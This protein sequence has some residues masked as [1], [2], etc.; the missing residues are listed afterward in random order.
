M[1]FIS[2]MA[3]FSNCRMF[4]IITDKNLAEF[5]K[6]IS[7]YIEGKLIASTF[8]ILL[9]VP[10]ML[11]FNIDPI[12]YGGGGGGFLARTIKLL[13]ITLKRLFLAPPDLATFSFYLLDTF[14]QNFSKVDSPGGCCSCF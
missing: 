6:K 7:K 11:V 8:D 2:I 5:L 13:T 1:T 4:K 10:W 12:T 14:W 9:I 3:T